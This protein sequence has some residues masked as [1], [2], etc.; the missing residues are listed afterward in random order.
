MVTSNDVHANSWVEAFAAYG[1]EVPFEKVSPLIGMG[2]DQLIPK[3]VPELNSEKGTGKAIAKLRKELL[4]DK[5]IPKITAANGSRNLILKMQ[6]SGLHLV[7]ASSA[8]SEELEIMLK[9][10]QVDDL[11]SEVTTSDDAEAS[12]PAPDIVEA[13]LNKGQM[14]PE[15][16]VMLG[17]SPYDIES[18]GKAG[19]AV[20]ALRCGGFSDEQLSGAIAIY[21]DPE[22]LLEHYDSSILGANA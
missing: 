17:D 4:F 16:V 8:S 9:I 6:K 13:A 14:T 21:N 1:L 19:V 20:I 15:K 5:Y 11:L 12:K 10:A 2:G 18:A 7:V 22:D 3:V